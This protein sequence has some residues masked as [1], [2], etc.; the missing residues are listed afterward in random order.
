M[1]ILK[2]NNENYHKAVF[3]YYPENGKEYGTLEIDKTTGEI[4]V[5]SVA[6]NDEYDRYLHHAVSEITKFY[7]NKRYERQSTVAWY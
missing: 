5:Q 7:K 2:M 1:L 3:N 4:N 6:K